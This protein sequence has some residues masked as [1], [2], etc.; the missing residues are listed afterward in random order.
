MIGWRIANFRKVPPRPRG[1]ERSPKANFTDETASQRHRLRGAP[2]LWQ[3]KYRAYIERFTPEF[4]G[5]PSGS[6]DI[7]PVGAER[8]RLRDAYG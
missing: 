7:V 2:V 3:P 1:N 8:P 4:G 6:E 5:I